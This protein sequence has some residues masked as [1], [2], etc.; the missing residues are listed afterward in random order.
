MSSERNPVNDHGPRAV[1]QGSE[2]LAESQMVVN[3]HP[4]QVQEEVARLA[5]VVASSTDGIITKDLSGN[6]TS[7][8]DAC[9]TIFGYRADEVLGKSVKLL[10]PK[11]KEGDEDVLLAKIRDGKSA[12]IH[13]AERVRKDGVSIWVSVSASPLRDAAGHIVGAADIKR[14]VTQRRKEDGQ[15]RRLASVVIDSNDAITVQ[16][17]DG[18]FEAWNKGAERMYGYSEAEALEMNNSQLVPEAERARA[19]DLVRQIRTGEAV[20]SLELQR[21]TKDGRTLDVWLTITKLL[22]NQ[23][24]IVGFAT[25]ERDITQRKLQEASRGR[26]AS[27]V[28]DSND[29]ITI[30]NLDG[31]ITAWNKGAHAMYGYTEAEAL[32]MN[33]RDTVPEDRRAQAL[34]LL[35]QAE[36]GQVVASLETQRVTKDG[37]ILD[38]W[39]TTTKLLDEQ[40]KITAIATTER[41]I[42]KRK[43]E[44]GQL[45]RLASVVL[46]SNDAITVQDLDGR[47]E[48]WNKGA[49]RMYGYTEAE[50]LGTDADSLGMNNS[51]LVPESERARALDLVRQ[52]R[53]GEPVD[54]VELQRVTKD[55]RILDVWLTITKLQDDK[56]K[57]IGFAT[58]ER[59]ITQ[60]KKDDSSRGR[61]ASVVADSNDAIT[62]QNLDGT[63]TAWNKGAHAM[64]GYTEAEALQMNIRDTVPEDR[65]EQALDLLRQA[66]T[67]QIVASLETQRVTK[68]GRILDVWLTTTKL[69][70]EKGKI[71]AIATT[72]RDI[73][74]RKQD[75]A[76]RGRL[77][78]VVA[79][80]N[81]AITIQN[82]DGKIT[83]WNK[84]AHAMYGYT[85][86]E[87]LQM[88]IRDTVPEDRRE[89]ALDLLRQAE[90]GQI[91]ASLETQRLTKDGRILDVW[92]TTTKLL[93]EQ[94]KIVAIATT[95]RDI[96]QRKR[97]EEELQAVDRFKTQFIN[98]AAHELRTPLLPLRMQLELLMT[99]EDHPPMPSQA[100]AMEVMHRNLDRLAG[101]V[102]DLLTV[103]RSQAGGIKVDVAPT[104]LAKV[105]NEAEQTF[106]TMADRRGILLTV[107]C[108]AVPPLLADGK[109]IG[110]VVANLLSNAFK[111]TP[112]G[113]EIRIR[114]RAENDGARISVSDN[115][116][117]IVQADI[118][119]LFKPFV[120]VHDATQVSFPGSGLGLYICKQLVEL[121]GGSIGCESPGRGKGSTF[122]FTLPGIPFR[123]ASDDSTEWNLT[124]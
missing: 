7:W 4:G 78:S 37:R 58:T 45:R 106:H 112:D 75:D 89:Q 56:K 55:G 50:A 1:R 64:Y 70:N 122:W 60:R 53:T 48:A 25:T 96:T 36:T 118:V 3:A 102:E 17:L 61:L 30:Q 71:V 63:I 100:E 57:V 38:V 41:D 44:D 16:D 31:Q 28:A 47:F 42:T 86:A 43:K 123:R 68:D 101:L 26:L 13:E 82:L 90:T 74:Q 91:V 35:R 103:A 27:V 94:G 105:L 65:R 77:A 111:F 66:E 46:D 11:G 119:R 108:T 79:D 24:K 81:D 92:L 9:R 72:E 88:N 93:D 22:D 80:S 59:D 87:A 23:Q 76:S 49:E 95:E 39:L 18:R 6:I 69:L 121:H 29:A 120:Q 84:G 97:A 8:N 40:G 52:I 124:P 73:T 34:F 51:Q 109:R 2:A 85:E 107:D 5:A 113:G 62:I 21:V 67:G 116:Q 110:Q 117:G 98:T 10:Y 33:I 99:D 104:D 114:L 12:R 115:G 83:A 32:R 20:D 14:D 19:L 54:S 15:L